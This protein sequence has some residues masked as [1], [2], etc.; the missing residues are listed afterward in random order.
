MTTKNDKSSNLFTLAKSLIGIPI[1]VIKSLTGTEDTGKVAKNV[2]GAAWRTFYDDTETKTDPED[3]RMDSAKDL[4]KAT[5]NTRPDL[6]TYAFRSPELEHFNSS[7][8][9]LLNNSNHKD[10]QDIVK[11]YNAKVENNK[12]I[13]QHVNIKQTPV[14]KTKAR[15]FLDTMTT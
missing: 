8:S 2:A 9:R 4:I 6:R 3:I 5:P 12:R 7:I 10:I 13:G 14:S 15:G 1:D 11:Y